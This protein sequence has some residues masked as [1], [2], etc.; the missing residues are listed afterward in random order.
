MAYYFA[1]ETEENTYVGK[2]I[3][4]SGYFGNNFTYKNHCEC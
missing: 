3:K 2:N 4:K 1:V